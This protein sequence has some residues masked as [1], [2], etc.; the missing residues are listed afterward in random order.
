MAEKEHQ[1]IVIVKRY[2]RD[3]EARHGGAW[4]IAFADFMTAMMALFLVLWLISSTSDKTKHSV[5]QYF[6]PVKLVDMTTLKKGFRDPKKTEMGAGPK[7]TESEID[8]DSNKDLAET[9][10]VAEHPGA[11]VRLISES[12]LFRDPYAAL[13][14]IAANAIEA[15]PHPSSG[16]PQSG[17]TEFS[18]ESSDVFVDPFTTA[19]RLAD[20]TVDGPASHAKPAIPERD[21]QAPSSPKQRAEP[22][23]HAEEQLSPPAGA[24][25]GTKTGDAATEAAMASA[26]PM[27][28]ET[29]SLKAGLTALAPQKGRFGDGPRIEVENTDEGLLISLTDDRKFSM[30][31]IGSAAPLPQTIEAMAKIGDLLKTRSGMVV[32]R[33]HTDARPFKSATYDNWRL[34]TARAHMAQYMLTRGG[35]DEKRIEKI[36]GFAD[37]RLKVAAEPT[38]A[39][40]RRI[41]ILL[42]KVKS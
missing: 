42:R 11:K 6:N 32:V 5:A 3:D 30:F 16:E 14:E 10:E 40:N 38:A 28:T 39:A 13:A 21:K 15:A 41:E 36:E 20:T 33:G 34:S 27:D 8:A 1:E 31:A 25:K 19:P 2:S 24:G 23:P 26:Q 22:L 7:T 37:H 18:V 12:K 35:L 29:A 4:K 17:P 9:Q